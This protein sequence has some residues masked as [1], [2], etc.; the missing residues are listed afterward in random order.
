[1]F[2]SFKKLTDIDPAKI[3]PRD[4]ST[5]VWTKN[6][7]LAG[8][9]SKCVTDAECPAF[10]MKCNNL[11]DPDVASNDT[12]TG[13][14]LPDTMINREGGPRCDVPAVGFGEYCA[15]AVSRCESH[16]TGAAV[17]VAHGLAAMPAQRW[18]YLTRR[19]EPS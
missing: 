13:L 12:P 4:T 9:A 8:Y 1:M 5:T 14:N 11:P 2:G 19:P 17:T 6:Y 3:T 7:P 10:G 18:A 16:V 15:P